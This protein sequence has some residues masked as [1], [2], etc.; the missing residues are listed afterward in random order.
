MTDSNYIKIFTGNFIIVQRIVNELEKIDINAIIKDQ[1]ESARLAGFGG[2]IIPG[3]QQVF[4]HKDEL[5]KAVNVVES[6]SAN[7]ET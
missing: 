7:L 4:V 2:G 5:D 3:F 1:T 6:I